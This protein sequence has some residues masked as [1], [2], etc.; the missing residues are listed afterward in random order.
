MGKLHAT[1][2][3]C[4]SDFRVFRVLE[5]RD[6][7]C[8][9]VLLRCLFTI[10]RG[11]GFIGSANESLLPR[12]A[13]SQRAAFVQKTDPSALVHLM[14]VDVLRLAGGTVLRFG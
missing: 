2:I 6:V 1:V 3:S 11:T 13:P 12:S 7:L 14:G 4:G 9:L 5:A 8:F 10:T